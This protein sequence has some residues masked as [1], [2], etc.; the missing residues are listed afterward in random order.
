MC[1]R[2]MCC[3]WVDEEKWRLKV[4]DVCGLFCFCL[5]VWEKLSSRWK[6]KRKP[7]DG[8][9]YAT[10]NKALC[11]EDVRLFVFVFAKYYPPRCERHCLELGQVAEKR[12]AAQ[13]LHV[14]LCTSRTW[15]GR[16]C[17]QINKHI[18]TH[19]APRIFLIT[20]NN[21]SICS[22]NKSANKFITIRFKTA[23]PA[24]IH[25]HI[26]FRISLV[27]FF[28]TIVPLCISTNFLF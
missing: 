4:L 8:K 26:P 15:C 19:S 13:K 3:V 17:I 21:N 10:Q 7:R 6:R 2:K 27:S 11:A 9:Q 1:R 18:N 24:N 5:C 20:K 12:S 28:H 23:P 25:A 16:K 22:C 14:Y